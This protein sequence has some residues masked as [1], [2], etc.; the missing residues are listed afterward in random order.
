MKNV[1]NIFFG[2]VA[3]FFIFYL[4]QPLNNFPK[5][6]PNAVQSE[7]EGDNED[8]NRRAYFTDFT[9]EEVIEFYKKDFSVSFFNFEPL[10]LNYPP[11]DSQTL[12]RDQTRSTFLEELVY[13]MRESIFINGFEP[14]DPKDEIWYKGIHYRQKIIIRYVPSLFIPRLVIGMATVFASYLLT[15]NMFYIWTKL[16]KK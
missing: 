9:R 7:E 1:F 4:Y 13:P 16:L 12:I 5:S 2:I 8:I 14:K 11:E 10:R 6:L 3:F 15:T